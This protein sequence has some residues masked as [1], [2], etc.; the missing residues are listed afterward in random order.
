[1]PNQIAVDHERA[2]AELFEDAAATSALT[3]PKGVAVDDF[4]F[5][6]ILL[7]D[8]PIARWH[9]PDRMMCYVKYCRL[10]SDGFVAWSYYKTT[11]QG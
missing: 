7:S 3:L 2:T 4:E 5:G 6:Q 1:M 8:F 9:A 10:K 11:P